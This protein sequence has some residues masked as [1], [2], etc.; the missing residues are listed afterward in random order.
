MAMPRIAGQY[1]TTVYE[2][3]SSGTSNL[4]DP[5]D[6]ACSVFFGNRQLGDTFVSKAAATSACLSF[7]RAAIEQVKYAGRDPANNPRPVAHWTVGNRAEKPI[8]G[9]Y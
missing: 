2:D 7:T 1:L 4:S 8:S 6:R 5:Q 3:H 9:N